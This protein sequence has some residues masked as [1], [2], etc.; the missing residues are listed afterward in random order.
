MGVSEIVVSGSIAIDRIMSF[1]GHYRD[2]I[3]PA[4]LHVL[5]VSVLV[6]SADT[7]E[8]GIGANICF[9]LA[10]FGLNPVLLGSVGDDAKD[11]IAD[12]K[13]RGVN[14]S[15]IHISQLATASFNVLND[16]EGNQVGGFYP[17]AMCDADSLSFKDFADPDTL[18]WVAPHDPAA[19]RRQ[20]DEAKQLGLRLGYDP[21]QQVSNISDDDLRAGI[22][23]AEIVIINEYELEVLCSKTGFSAEQLA[24]TV[25]LL[26]TTHGA[27]GSS[28]SGK[29]VSSPLQ[30]GSVKPTS[31]VDPG[32][33]GDAYRGGF[34]YGY[35]RQW[36][37]K[38]CGQLGATLAA[39]VI[40]NFGPQVRVDL[41]ELAARYQQNF[42][43]EIEFNGR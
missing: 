29:N 24:K 38:K 26:I 25:P 23:A 13:S 31:L 27:A 22:E 17:G 41:S 39:F 30:I 42:N 9:N 20:C 21:G 3:E 33:A 5:S 34:L 40:E 6:D 43:E 28:I 4:K 15:H 8:G 18:F 37:L 35:L 32:G 16:V 36:D 14:T 11:Y 2:L 10:G 19:M 12:L 7:A 1:K